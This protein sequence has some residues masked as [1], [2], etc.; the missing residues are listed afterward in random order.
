ML[1]VPGAKRLF[2]LPWRTRAE[3]RADVDDEV[4]FHLEARARTVRHTS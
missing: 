1:H 4:A 3:V 2:R